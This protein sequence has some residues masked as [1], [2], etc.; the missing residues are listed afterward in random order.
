MPRCVILVVAVGVLGCSR[1][2]APTPEVSAAPATH[3]PVEPT[4]PAPQ[5]PAVAPKQ[6]DPKKI[7]AEE[8]T[9][10][11]FP[12]DLAGKSLPKTVAPKAPPLPGTERFGQ[13]PKDRTP[14]A[15]L[16]D[17]Q[18]TTKL[19]VAP[20]P[21]LLPRPEGFKPVAP[22]ER[23]PLDLGLGADGVP[24]K[25]LLP[26][27]PGVDQKARDVNLPPNLP[28]LGRPL[29]DRAP[30]DDPTAE[31]GN[32]V[33]VD[34]SVPPALAPSGFLKFGL[35]DPFELADQVKPRVPPTAEPAAFPVPVNPQRVK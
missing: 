24:A 17:P 3:D 23:V 11:V 18:P 16:L 34:R 32:T 33:I 14:P 28:P 12:T 19:A 27:S 30:L 31:P 10:F 8:P 5:R 7:T 13:A 35:P 26:E 9:A 15:Q 29:P 20:Q 21:V 25:P 6:P 22:A 1:P 2:S 4:P